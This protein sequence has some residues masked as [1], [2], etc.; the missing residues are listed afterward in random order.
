MTVAAE[1]N[2]G[3]QSGM[4][5]GVWGSAA[6]LLLVPLVAMQFTREVHWDLADFLLFGAMLAAACGI[7]EAT[8]RATGDWAY[9]GAVAI[10]IVTGFALVWIN[11]AVGILER[12]DANLMYGAVIAAA[13]IGAMIARFRPTG[14]ALAMTATAAAQAAVM[15]IAWGMEL[16]GAPVLTAGFVGL[17][18]VS[19]W[20]F[21]SAARR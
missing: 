9:R 18:L 15:A 4:R 13:V 2:H 20:L 7:W 19:A 3:R 10:A 16:G 12:D 17:W 5:W 21:R 1:T 11:L 8:A 6:A 14:M